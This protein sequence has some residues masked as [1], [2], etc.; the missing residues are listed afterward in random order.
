M[1]HGPHNPEMVYTKNRYC[2]YGYRK[3]YSPETMM[4]ED[5]YPIY[6]RRPPEEGGNSLF[7]Y[8]KGK[9]ATY[10]NGDVVPTTSI[11]CTNITVTSMLNIAIQ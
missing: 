6:R 9:P 11:F 3:E 5:G 10:T 4:P 2:Q 7:T 8:R 1:L